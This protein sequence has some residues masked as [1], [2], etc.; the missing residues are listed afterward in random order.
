MKCKRLKRRR[1]SLMSVEANKETARRFI[2]E[3]FNQHQLQNLQ[4]FAAPDYINHDPKG[5]ITQGPQNITAFRSAAPDLHATITQILGEGDFVPSSGP[6]QERI[7]S[8]L[9]I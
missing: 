3:V 7:S 4:E 1:T 8:H 5:H 9:L 6:S 2:D